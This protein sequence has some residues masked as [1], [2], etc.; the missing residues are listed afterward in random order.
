MSSSPT[1]FVV[2]DDPSIRKTICALVESIGVATEAYGTASEF[3]SAYNPERPGCLVLDVHLPGLSGLGL[4]KLL[5][6]KAI[7]VPIVMISGDT[8]ASIAEH[9]VK[10]GAFRFLEKPFKP[11]VLL[12]CIGEV[13]FIDVR[14]RRE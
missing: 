1:V 5:K 4:A 14:K 10:A 8:D 7:A 12:N 9:A 11:E 3:L 13:L 6:E 2:D